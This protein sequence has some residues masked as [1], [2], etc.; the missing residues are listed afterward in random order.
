MADEMRTSKL[1]LLR[2][3]SWTGQEGLLHK[4]VTGSDFSGCHSFSCLVC[5]PAVWLGLF[6]ESYRCH[7]TQYA[8][9]ILLVSCFALVNAANK[10]IKLSSPPLISANS[11][12]DIDPSF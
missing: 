1:A 10:Q 8:C 7:D 4:P 11:L 5:A 2:H 12:D 3:E 9:Y 6:N